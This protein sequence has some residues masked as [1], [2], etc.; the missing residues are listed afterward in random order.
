MTSTRD[1]KS[2]YAEKTWLEKYGLVIAIDAIVTVIVVT[3]VCIS[4]NCK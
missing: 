4:V 3:A 2:K 1:Q